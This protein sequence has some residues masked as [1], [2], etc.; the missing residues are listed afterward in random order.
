MPGVGD[1][2]QIS[3]SGVLPGIHPRY[4]RPLARGALPVTQYGMPRNQSEPGQKTCN[5]PLDTA[6]LLQG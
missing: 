2:A 1:S 4:E 5:R 3:H 6:P